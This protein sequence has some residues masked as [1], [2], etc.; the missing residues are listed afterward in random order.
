M[1]S[2]QVKFGRDVLVATA[3]TALKS[4]RNLL[5]LP[6][7]TH[8]LS[9]ADFGLWS[10]IA[11]GIAIAIPWISLRLNSALI[12]FLPGKED[13][14]EVLEGFYSIFFFTFGS[15]SICALL[16][17]AFFPLLDSFPLFRPFL[18]YSIYICTLI[19]LTALLGILTTYFRAFRLIVRH[20]ML[21]LG[22]HFSEIILTGWTLQSGFGLQGVLL[23]LILIRGL[24]T[25]ISF[26]MV[27]ALIGIAFPR[28]SSLKAFLRYSIP[29]IPNST[30]YLIFDAADRF[31]IN[32]F[33]GN[34]A[35]GL[36]S[37][38]YTAGSFFST[39]TAPIHLVLFP[40]MAELW[41]S[42][43]R[44]EL[45]EYFFHT[46]RFTGMFSLPALAGALVLARPLF[47][48]LVP[49]AYLA[50]LPYFPLLALSFLLFSFGVAGGNLLM[51]AGQ[52][53]LLLALDGTMALAN[54][55]LN[56]SL[57]PLVG[58]YGS[59]LS[60]LICHLLYTLA[61]LILSHRILSSHFPWK[62]LLRCTIA[63]LGMAALLQLLVSTWSPSLLVSVLAGCISYFVVLWALRGLSYQ[64]LA[65]AAS[66]F[67]RK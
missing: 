20:S 43:N 23:A 28:F 26:G 53:R 13:K 17:Y 22:Q 25:I 16:F 27:I 50:A 35:V 64:D 40:L 33:L 57:I 9:E 59:V 6:L 42:Q 18:P 44:S 19:P 38:A 41:N 55:L 14:N 37:A 47:S 60:M 21:T 67:R 29:L 52:T 12:R 51:T 7:L 2:L 58:I 32:F 24:I 65:Y 31:I 49:S 48:L 36:Y 34:V 30:T 3:A 15:S 56:I 54:I 8:G 5:M 1:S 10:Q 66:L 46:L 62:D 63:S 4:L 45:K 39:L 61:T 11:G